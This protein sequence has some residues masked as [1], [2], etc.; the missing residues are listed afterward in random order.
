MDKFFEEIS[1]GYWWLAVVLVGIAINIISS[2]LK[3]FME[4]SFSGFSSYWKNKK[5]ERLA[6]ENKKIELLSSDYELKVVYALSESRYRI[7]SIG[8]FLFGITFMAFSFV[9]KDQSQVML[10]V[11][12]ISALFSFLVGLSDHRDAIK[13]KNRVNQSTKSMDEIDT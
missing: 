13:V 1:S 8:F 6:S 10:G 3:K 11:T 7:R 2:Y 4:S 5:D 9:V 12:S